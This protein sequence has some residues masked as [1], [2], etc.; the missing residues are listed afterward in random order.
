MSE[1]DQLILQFGLGA[2]FVHKIEHLKQSPR[3]SW[4]TPYSDTI[5]KI[6]SAIYGLLIA[7]GLT[8]AFT[9]A[10]DGTGTFA[11]GHIPMTPSLIWQ[12]VMHAF[13]QY[14]GQKA[15][16]VMGVKKVGQ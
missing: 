10:G 15:Y 7:A 1:V 4:I 3:F 14:W 16:Y 12:A 11:I 13:G 8:I 5:T 6:I 2:Y 9:P